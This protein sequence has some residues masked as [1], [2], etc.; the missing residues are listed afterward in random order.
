MALHTLLDRHAAYRKD[1]TAL[2]FEG[3]RYSWSELRDDV[4]ALITG[5]ASE[6]VG[7][8]DHVALL[9]DNGVPVVQL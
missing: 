2:V 3:T 1:H 8:G 4:D 5:L 9:L 7:R 6:G